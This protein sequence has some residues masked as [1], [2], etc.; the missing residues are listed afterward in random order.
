MKMQTPDGAADLSWAR[1]SKGSFWLD[2]HVSHQPA[3]G[4][5]ENMAVK[6]PHAGALVEDDEEPDGAVDRHVERV[7]PGHRVDR[8]ELLVE[9][10]EEEAVQM[11]RM[12]ELARVFHRPD[13][14]FADP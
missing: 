7:L 3:V 5:V 12:R 8:F 14:R 1:S 4:V 2:V 10:Q 6:H 9:R 13:L 11:K